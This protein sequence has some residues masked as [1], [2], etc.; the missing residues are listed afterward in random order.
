MIFEYFA[1][2]WTAFRLMTE[3]IRVSFTICKL[4]D[5]KTIGLLTTG[6]LISGLLKTGPTTTGLVDNWSFDY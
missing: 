1:L 2:V 3:L 6:L 4:S 5:R